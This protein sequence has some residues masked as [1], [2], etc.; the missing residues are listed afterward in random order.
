MH[1]VHAVARR[2]QHDPVTGVRAISSHVGVGNWTWAEQSG[3]SFQSQFP[4]L[5]YFFQKLPPVCQLVDIP[6][7]EIK[8]TN[9]SRIQDQ[10]SITVLVSICITLQC[11]TGILKLLLKLKALWGH[12]LLM[13]DGGGQQDPKNEVLTPWTHLWHGQD[14][15]KQAERIREAELLCEGRSGRKTVPR[16]RMR[17]SFTS[18]WKRH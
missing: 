5:N 17:S 15:K 4:A 10:L 14:R 12:A 18:V 6:L 13:N 11:H 9:C 1:H 7:L 8:R 3:L 16:E 2:G